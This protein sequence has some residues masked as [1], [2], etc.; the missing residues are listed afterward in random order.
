MSRIV[1]APSSKSLWVCASRQV[2]WL[3][4]RTPE[5][6]AFPGSSSPVAGKARGFSE[7]AS[8]LAAHSG[9]TAPD[10]NRLPLH[11]DALAGRD[12]T[13]ILPARQLHV[14]PVACPSQRRDGCAPAVLSRPVAW[15]VPGATPAVSR[16]YRR[17]STTLPVHSGSW[18]L[19]HS[20]P[21]CPL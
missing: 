19:Y 13:R 14:V 11:R 10:F 8:G 15:P 18:R 17:G 4:A 1:P 16:S 5:S 12:A 9:G 7:A 3:A 20:I 6:A 21:F 2:S